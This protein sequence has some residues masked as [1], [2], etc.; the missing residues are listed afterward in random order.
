MPDMPTSLSS[1]S[2]CGTKAI[3]AAII[4]ELGGVRVVESGTGR[5]LATQP[6]PSMC[7][8]VPRPH[9]GFAWLPRP[10]ADDAVALVPPG[11]RAQRRSKE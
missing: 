6:A 7:V 2:L 11:T 1:Y 8:L 5:V 3:P 4:V 9:E 10:A